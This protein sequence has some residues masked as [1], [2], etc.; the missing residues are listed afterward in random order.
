[1]NP[2]LLLAGVAGLATL[3]SACG[4]EDE[5]GLA[6]DS[7]PPNGPPQCGNNPDRS[8][9]AGQNLSFSLQASDP[10]ADH[11][12]YNPLYLPEGASLSSSGLFSW[13]P[14]AAQGGQH[15]ISFAVSDGESTADCEVSV[16]VNRAPELIPIPNQV[17]VQGQILKLTVLASDPDG[18]IPN[19][20]A[21]NLPSGAEFNQV[22]GDQ[23]TGIFRWGPIANAPGIYSVTFS[24]SDWEET[25]SQTVSIEVLEAN[26]V[27]IAAGSNSVCALLQ[28][29][30]VTCWGNG[31]DSDFGQLTP[32]EEG[33]FNYLS[34]GN[35]FFGCG[36]LDSGGIECWGSNVLGQSTPPEGI[37]M[38]VSAGSSF[39]CGVLETGGI[40][41]W[42]FNDEGQA[43]PP[44]GEFVQVSAGGNFTCGLLDTGAVLCWGS[45]QYGQSTPPEGNFIQLS[46]SPSGFGWN[47]ACGI[48]DTG[49]VECWGYDT[50]WQPIPQVAFEKISAGDTHVCGLMDSG[51]VQ[52]WGGG[53]GNGHFTFP[54]GTFTDISSGSNFTC[55]INPVG[56][57]ECAGGHAP[58]PPVYL[59]P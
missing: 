23:A 57:V 28:N 45:D 58:I 52:C 26:A 38:D 7:S 11:L 59:A 25:V 39:A 31:I 9:T 42:G 53:N 55:A 5:G 34:M 19:L 27:Q 56:K 41:C 40:T 16:Y 46:T 1:M 20:S 43:S 17:A 24:A 18:T 50:F 29:G 12:I 47:F 21:D 13:M 48:L 37:F 10:D 44:A 14:T 8:I 54:D 49:L 51:A 22:V 35:G 6:A 30:A 32:P 4:D 15:T 36:I 33:R 2:L 3:L